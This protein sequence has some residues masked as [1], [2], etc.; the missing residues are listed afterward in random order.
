MEA[1]DVLIRDGIVVTLDD[2]DRILRGSVA[3]QDGRI[4]AVGPTEELDA[5][6]EAGKTLDARERIVLPGLIDMHN[7]LRDLAPGL[8]VGQGLKLDDYL[9]AG[10]EMQQHLTA[11]DYYLGATL[12]AIRLLKA[13]VTSVVDHCYPF[14]LPGLEEAV[15]RAF[16]DVGI[17]GYLARGIMTK[18][19]EPICE[20]RG[21][22][23]E[24]IRRLV[25]EGK[26]PAERLFIA[27]VSFRQ[28]IPDDYREA[29]RLA[30]DL[31]VGTYTHI[32]ET[33]Q[34]VEGIIGEYGEHPIHFLHDLGFSGPKTVLVHCVLLEDSE[35]ER[36]AE[37]R[38]TVV[39]CPSNH[40]K[41]A[42][43]ITRVP[44]LLKAGVNM[45]L[46]VDV[47]ENLWVEMRNELQL[48]SIANLNPQAVSPTAPLHMATRNAARARRPCRMYW[49][50]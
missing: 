39:H 24:R 31:G 21:E 20:T 50:E 18:P 46:G 1:V 9:R 30:D 44:D 8:P 5:A 45:T 42:K 40:M 2:E 37:D 35:I 41:L 32:A 36:L 33:A 4:V 23:L 43:G 13:G 34:E 17:R 16:G 49:S 19:F 28:A 29:R 27:P 11:E 26:V 14:H 7:H 48:Q 22:A 6:V 38:T 25:D 15:L 3:V 47:M 10:W 12:G